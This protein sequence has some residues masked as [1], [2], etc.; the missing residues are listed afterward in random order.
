MINKNRKNDKQNRKINARKLYEDYL[1]GNKSEYEVTVDEAWLYQHY[2]DGQTKKFYV[3]KGETAPGNWV[4]EQ[5]ESFPKGFIAVGGIT[6]H[7]PLLLL[8]IPKNTKISKTFFRY[9]LR[10]LM[11]IHL[12]KIYPNE[13]DKVFYHHDKASFHT[14]SKTQEYLEEECL[15]MK[16]TYIKNKDIPIKS[17]DSSPMD[18]F[19]FWH[20]KQ[21]LFQLSCDNSRWS[22]EMRTTGVE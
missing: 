6:G 16:I 11:K 13:M 17:P 21:K 15:K 9:V 1:A 7:G 12:P 20:L 4:R 5:D 18:F 8:R 10:P 3:K 19:G 22:L 14:S 2:C